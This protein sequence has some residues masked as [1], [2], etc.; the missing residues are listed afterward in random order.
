MPYGNGPPDPGAPETRSRAM[1][2]ILV[3]VIA[4]V[5]FVYRRLR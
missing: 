4:V 3:V 2:W 1:F 5:V